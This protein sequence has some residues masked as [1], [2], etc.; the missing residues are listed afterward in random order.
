M[1]VV[2]GVTLLFH[3]E[4]SRLTIW[5]SALVLGA[6]FWLEVYSITRKSTKVTANDYVIFCAF[7]TVVF[8]FCHYWFDDEFTRHFLQLYLP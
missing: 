6:L 8:I 2:A 4:V 7:I 3:W 1:L 5:I